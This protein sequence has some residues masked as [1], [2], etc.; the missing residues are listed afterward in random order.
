MSED[1]TLVPAKTEVISRAV[2]TPGPSSTNQCF[3]PKTHWR[4]AG[5][6][7]TATVPAGY[8]FVRIRY[9]HSSG[10]ES[11]VNLF[12][13]DFP[14]GNGEVLVP[15]DLPR[16]TALNI[17]LQPGQSICVSGADVETPTPESAHS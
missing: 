4:L 13:V 7:L 12:A 5:F 9:Q 3:P 11:L 8:W 2:V 16:T 1:G 17:A 14:P 15:M 6:P 10:F